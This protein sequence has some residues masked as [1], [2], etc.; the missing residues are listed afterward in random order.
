MIGTEFKRTRR[1]RSL[2]IAIVVALYSLTQSQ[3]VETRVG[4]PKAVSEV[5]FQRD[6]SPILRRHCDRCHG[7]TNQE[8]G[9][10]LS[11]REGLFGSA[12]S[13]EPIVVPQDAEA[14]LL[15]ARIT[16]ESWGDIMPLDGS[17][18]E[19][20]EIDVLRRWIEQGGHAPES[21]VASQHWAYEIPADPEIPAAERFRVRTPVDAFIT[22]RLPEVSLDQSPRAEIGTLVRRLSLALTGLPPSIDDL[23]AM[24]SHSSDEAIEDYVERL[25]SSKAFGEHW[26]RHWLD[27][28]RYADSNGYQADQLRDSWA[29][30]DWVIDAFN[31][32]MPFDQFVVEQLAGDLIP[33]ANL[34]SRI[35]TGFHRTVTCNIEAGVH[36]EANRV[37]Q[38]FDRVNTTG[39][40]F[41]GST[42]EC[43]Q[44]H[45]HKYDPFSQKEYYE[46]FAF[47]NNTPIEV[48]KNSGVQYDFVGPKMT[49]PMT[50]PQQ[51]RIERL[52]QRL[53]DKQRELKRRVEDDQTQAHIKK[54]REALEIGRAEWHTPPP[55]FSSTGGED[56]RL[57]D[58]QSVL[59]TG[60]VPG[61]ATYEFRFAGDGQI[62][63]SIRLETLR[64]EELPGGGPGRGDAKR[65]NFV[66]N[67]IE[68]K[69]QKGE[70][71]EHVTLGDAKASFSQLKWDVG[72]VIDG[73]PKTGWAI[74][75]RFKEEFWATFALVEPV[76]V[77]RDEMVVIT[78]DQQFGRGRVIGRPRLSL[79]LG[80]RETAGLTDDI[81]ELLEKNELNGKE[82]KKL[83][84]FFAEQ[85]ADVQQLKREI[86][87]IQNEIKT[88][89]PPSTLVMVESDRPRETHILL[90]GDYLS[91]GDQVQP[92]TPAVL[93]PLDPELP[94]N[95]LGLAKWLV[96]PKNPLL[97]RVTVNRLWGEVFGRPLVVTAEDFGTQSEPASHPELLDWLANQ[98]IDSGWSVRHVL[99][100]MV[101]SATFQQS[102]KLSPRMV[103]V[104]K[105]N[106]WLARGP[107]YRLPAEAIRDNA[108]AIS[109]LLCQKSGGEP[110]MPYQPNGLWR[111]VGRNQ[112]KWIASDGEDRYRRGLYV[113]W[114][115]AAPYPSF[116][117]FDAPDR[118]SCT[119]QRPR[120]NTPLQALTLL[121]DRAY[122]EASVG[123]AQRLIKELPDA[124]SR[125]RAI[126]AFRITTSTEPNEETLGLLL[127][128]VESESKRIEAEPSLV[129]QR[130]SVLPGKFR[131]RTTARTDVAIWSSIT[132]VLL[133]LDQTI[134]VN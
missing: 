106:Q 36:P 123:F 91:E 7:Q 108:L 65:T 62:L 43:A 10:N 127:Q 117:T 3:G 112:P 80:P 46:L 79:L 1:P 107:R 128:L 105:E 17:S 67:E 89:S 27:L 28:A 41:L 115:R 104:D 60:S 96:D 74:A 29:Y 97:A 4:D 8:A 71:S 94:R 54:V 14:S 102:S 16:D 59:I 38:V 31:K 57:L 113:V 93:H 76:Q 121:N 70:T 101:Y 131:D 53:V 56:I 2:S 34:S 90:R 48:K 66:L 45:D 15:I 51:S 26:A 110:I 61:T 21:L 6:V 85:N 98:F 103:A 84:E 58:D 100:L 125:D 81:V 11:T 22:K 24:E 75:P 50:S 13:D 134:T 18:L 124:S 49:L 95:R 82:R 88:I 119:V 5:D 33:D 19:T 37:Q 86:K 78:L 129:D 35:A 87:S 132:S 72:G 42:L 83:H 120:T 111:S 30:R 25:M 114:K 92:A 116:V 99:R 40:V 52:N 73:N 69:I 55:Q 9:L 109:G 12:D 39:T 77:G 32:G 126:H 68:L 118:A 47:F 63:S 64:H 20:H 44:C 122:A 23:E 130:L 133:N